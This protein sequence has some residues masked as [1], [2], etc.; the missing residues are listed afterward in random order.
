MMWRYPVKSL[1][2]EPLAQAELTPGG[3][4]GDRLVHV[5]TGR[6]LLTG[7]TRPGLLT[8]PAT[9][10]ADG[11]PL[12]AGHPWRSPTAARLVRERAGREADLVA[13]DGPERF[14][15]T[16]LL[17]AT[18]G[19]LD[20]FGQRHGAPLDV[21]RL[22][23]NLVLAGAD[24]DDLERWPGRALAIGDA[25]VG[26]HS[27]RPRCVVT[28]IDPDTGVQDLDVFRRI[29]R[30]FANLMALNCWV[31]TPGTVRVGDRATLVATSARPRDV[32]GWVVGAPDAQAGI[33]A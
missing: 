24:R 14:D 22:R 1:A 23:P 10:G 20:A 31:I 2:G 12:V 3:L 9:T 32:G 27:R 7:R 25:L 4:A 16:N 5:R 17:V 8:L 28:S 29:R 33:R 11:E 18:D 15:V 6:G 13:Y 30:D 26:V 21:R 19:E